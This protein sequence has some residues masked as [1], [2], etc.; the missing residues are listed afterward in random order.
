MVVLNK[1]SLLVCGLLPLFLSACVSNR[2]GDAE[3]KMEEIRAQSAMPISPLPQPEP[4]EDFTYSAS[5]VRSPFLAPSL[6][7][8][9]TQFEKNSG[10]KP[11]INRKKEPL[12]AYELSQ[13]VYHGRVVS[14]DGQEYGLIRLP[15]GYVK[16]VKVGQYIGK[17]DGR[18]LEITPT[19][20]NIEE[21]VPDSRSG[22]TYKKTA[23]VTPN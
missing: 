16:E 22:F 21:I 19:Q 18:I 12:E 23:L 4:I 3:Q 11:D 14:I 15:D 10:I 9:Q 6:I 20:I 13:L 8:M 7:S 2:T 5:E 1:K 17:S